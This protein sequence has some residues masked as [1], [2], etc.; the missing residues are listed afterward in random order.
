MV[1][2]P[3]ARPW[4]VF[5]L[6]TMSVA[7]FSIMNVF[8]KL[9]SETHAVVEVM[10]FRNAL[11]VIPVLFLIQAH[12][13]GFA[14]LKTRKPLGHLLRGTVGTISMTFM[15]WS[16]A[17][18]PLADATALQFAM[19]LMLTALSVPFLKEVVGPWRTGAVIAGFIGVMVIARPSGDMNFL[20]V[21]V[22]LMAAFLTACVMIIIRRL[23]RTEHAL[24]IVFYFSTFGAIISAVFLPWYWSP[25]S[26]KTF[27]YLV[28]T[29]IC[30]GVAQVFVTKAYAEAP[31]AYVSP[32]SYLA[33]IFGSVFGWIIWNQ[34]PTTNVVIGSTIV[35]FSGLFILYRETVMKKHL[36]QDAVMD[37]PAPTEADE[38]GPAPEAQPGE[39]GL[40]P[41]MM[42]YH[43]PIEDKEK[44][45]Q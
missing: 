5:Y 6:A 38:F 24:T 25:P 27:I 36:V 21:G 3:V 12:P 11:A 37:A 10:F 18:L 13:E 34:P 44:P 22:A 32:F 8:V 2:T 7:L 17:L 14:L 30:G 45:G 4:R 15:F 1:E 39:T 29:G 40:S 19:P 35:V 26:F 20:G 9:A 31:A 41:E 28:M 42:T 23:G 16:F 43:A 33:I